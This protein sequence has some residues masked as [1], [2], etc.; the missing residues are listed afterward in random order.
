MKKKTGTR[1][2][3]S[4]LALGVCM[5]AQA[6][7]PQTPTTQATY[8]GMKVGIDAKTGKLRPLTAAESQ[9]LDQML[10]Q[11]RQPTFAPG[12]AKTFNTPADEAAARATAHRNVHGGVSVKL[13]ESQM[14]TVSVHREASGQLR[15]EHS[16]EAGNAAQDGGRSNE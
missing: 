9:Q 15:I 12:M 6:A 7:E 5:S 8:S 1:V 4:G 3:L 16:D 10:T 13:P 2:L 11:G 14:S